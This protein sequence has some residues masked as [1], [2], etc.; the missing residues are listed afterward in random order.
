MVRKQTWILLGVFAVLLG[1]TFYLQKNPLP[2][3]TAKI[4]PSATAAPTILSGWQEA[5]ITGIE[6]KEGDASV[7]Q[8][9]K[10]AQGNWLYGSNKIK[11]EAGKAAQITAQMIDT[12]AV[13]TLPADF[14]LDTIGLNKPAY[15]LIL[16]AQNKQAEIHIG[17]KTPTGDGYYAQ[18][19]KNAPVVVAQTVVDGLISQ[20]KDVLPTP[21]AATNPQPTTAP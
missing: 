9:T 6:L 14:A 2:Q 13:T 5:E 1:V 16:S 4:T 10:D 18:V 19:D 15:N 21:T 11:I 20:L 12:R 7:S 17:G 3:S 8:L